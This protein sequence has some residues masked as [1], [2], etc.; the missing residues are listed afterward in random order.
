MVYTLSILHYLNNRADNMRRTLCRWLSYP[1][2]LL[3]AS[4]STGLWSAAARLKN[5]L[6]GGGSFLHNDGD[7][8]PRD[9]QD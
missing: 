9:E 1:G 2:D 8:E 5:D 4:S 7:S 3:R 6:E